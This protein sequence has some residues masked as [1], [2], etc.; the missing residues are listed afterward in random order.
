MLGVNEEKIQVKKK[1]KSY[2]HYWHKDKY[3]LKMASEF[4]HVYNDKNLLSIICK[5][6]L[7]SL[8]SC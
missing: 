4:H 1:H 8:W 2:I 7:V 3:S 6:P 5:V